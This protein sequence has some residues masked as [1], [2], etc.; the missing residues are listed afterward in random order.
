MGCCIKCW[1]YFCRCCPCCK[2]GARYQRVG[3]DELPRQRSEPVVAIN[4]TPSYHEPQPADP[5]PQLSR[6]LQSSTDD[7]VPMYSKA[8][9]MVSRS[10][11]NLQRRLSPIPSHKLLSPKSSTNIPLFRGSKQHEHMQS[12]RSLSNRRGY[13]SRHPSSHDLAKSQSYRSGRSERSHN[14]ATS[15]RIKM[16]APLAGPSLSH[17]LAHI[18]ASM[19]RHDS[20]HAPSHHTPSRQP[21]HH[22]PSHHVPSHHASSHHVPS[23]RSQHS[24]VSG[25]K[26]KMIP[27]YS[28]VAAHTPSSLHRTPTIS[29]AGLSPHASHQQQ[30]PATQLLSQHSPAHRRQTLTSNHAG[31]SPHA[32][33]RQHTPATSPTG[34]SPYASHRKQSHTGLSPHASHRRQTLT[35]E[36]AGL[37]PRASYRQQTPATSRTGSPYASDRQRTPATSRSG[38]SPHASHR[39]QTLASNHAGLSPLASYR[40]QTS[41]ASL[42]GLSPNRQQTPATSPI[43]LSPHA[44]HRQQSLVAS[45]AG[46]SPYAPFQQSRTRELR[47]SRSRGS[48]HPASHH[49]TPGRISSLHS[50]RHSR[51]HMPQTQAARPAILKRNSVPA[52][53]LSRHGSP[54]PWTTVTAPSQSTHRRRSNPQTP[55]T[56]PQFERI[57]GTQPLPYITSASA[58]FN[59][60]EEFS[61]GAR[62]KSSDLFLPHLNS[63]TSALSLSMSQQP[64]RLPGN[65]QGYE[66]IS[67]SSS[68]MGD[69]EPT[70]MDV[71]H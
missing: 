68:L 65:G 34:L 19:S 60:A 6:L 7:E 43:R 55:I 67:L 21:S 58:A 18:S 27:K 42:T 17:D 40:Q 32:S 48:H 57:S 15:R 36:H 16:P 39:R 29:H 13:S 12:L 8:P 31:L 59:T 1:K 52:N 61:T 71:L 51:P 28:P 53:H 3:T 47:G 64:S 11:P 45:R 9:S 23:T 62:G 44:S 33:Y 69:S 63:G 30:M 37:S 5:A 46:M 20:H 50:K 4:E 38:L 25:Y 26:F 41:A 22:A 54:I 14:T 24:A 56:S 49:Q 70:A 66:L 10:S 35:S 2:G